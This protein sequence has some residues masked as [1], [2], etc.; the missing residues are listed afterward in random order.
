MKI[1]S[2]NKKLWLTT[3]DR[4]KRF[5]IHTIPVDTSG[6]IQRLLVFLDDNTLAYFKQE[7]V[8]YVIKKIQIN[9][10]LMIYLRHKKHTVEIKFRDEYDY[11]KK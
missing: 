5:D 6:L 10:T 9:R 8:L 2:N 7:V 4:K 3:C 1:S 11:G